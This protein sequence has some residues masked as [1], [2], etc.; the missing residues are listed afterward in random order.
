[1]SDKCGKKFK[2]MRCFRYILHH[3][4]YGKSHNKEGIILIQGHHQDVIEWIRYPGQ[5]ERAERAPEFAEMD[6]LLY[7][8]LFASHLCPAIAELKEA[9]IQHN[10]NLE[11]Q[12]VVLAKVPRGGL[13]ATDIL[14]GLLAEYE[15]VGLSFDREK[16]KATRQAYK[17]LQAEPSSPQI[18]QQFIEALKN[19]LS[20]EFRASLRSS[21]DA[22][23]HHLLLPEDIADSGNTLLFMTE[24][25]AREVIMLGHEQ[26]TVSILVPSAS[27]QSLSPEF[28]LV[29][30]SQAIAKQL[31]Q[32]FG[33]DF[34]LK[35]QVF[36]LHEENDAEYLDGLRRDKHDHGTRISGVMESK[37]YTVLKAVL[38]QALPTHRQESQPLDLRVMSQ[39]L[40]QSVLAHLSA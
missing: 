26:L 6:A 37:Y 14:Q 22:R 10:P 33:L 13:L 21:K 27:D 31:S 3:V 39:L 28:G 38:Y 12:R 11:Q 35:V 7:E 29:A 1:M 2:Q 19:L 15:P 5:Q 23:E 32:E 40:A 17:A 18:Q 16:I 34:K 30:R 36:T 9:F 8:V 20:N 4:M 25:Y 24:A